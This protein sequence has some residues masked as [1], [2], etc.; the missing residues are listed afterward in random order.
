MHSIITFISLFISHLLLGSIKLIWFYTFYVG[1]VL[2]FPSS[3]FLV[4]AVAPV[5]QFG[6]VAVTCHV[7]WPTPMMMTLSRRARMLRA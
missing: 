5:L 7:R 2:G 6:L 1:R 3:H 4:A